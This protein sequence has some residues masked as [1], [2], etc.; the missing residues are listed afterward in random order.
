VVYR[1][2]RL[3]ILL[4]PFALGLSAC[5]TVDDAPASNSW[6]AVPSAMASE[7]PSKPSRLSGTRIARSRG[8]S[9]WRRRF[10]E[11][12]MT[13]KTSHWDAAAPLQQDGPPVALP[14]SDFN[15]DEGGTTNSS[16]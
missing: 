15:M 2:S 13:R 6:N 11:D 12:D 10:R 4:L 8:P 3:R 1:T 9:N 5:Q 16:V 7:V 14:Q